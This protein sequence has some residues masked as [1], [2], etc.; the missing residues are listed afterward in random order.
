M[1]KVYQKNVLIL[2]GGGF[3]GVNLV[4]YLLR[5][6]KY[7]ITILDSF[8]PRF[9]SNENNLNDVRDKIELIRG[10]I[11]DDALLK[12]VI[13]GKDII[14]NL[15][16][17]TSHPI[18]IK[19]PIFDIEINCIGALKVLCAVKDFNK[20]AVLVYASS[21]TMVGKSKKNFIDEEH[22]ENPLDIY[23]ANKGVAEKYHK[24]F[25]NVYGVKTISLRF[26][27]LYGPFGKNDPSSGFLN[28]FLNLALN[29]RPITVFG[30]GNQLRNVMFV[31]DACDILLI[32]SKHK[33]LFGGAY[34]AVHNE[35]KSVKE[36]AETVAKVF[37]SKVEFVPY[38]EIRKKMEV[39]HQKISG[40]LLHDLTGWKP[41]Y[42]FLEGLKEIRNHYH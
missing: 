1:K 14:F 19:N 21:S 23:S 32:A 3:L 34:F 8:D 41:N 4:K 9:K 27:N 20:N 5:N 39:D 18:S 25:A 2:G 31:E 6:Q 10:D 26:A 15:A 38:P 35:H 30:D 36:I 42:S 22:S 11:L 17:Q 7:N 13:I 12:K 28:Y 24:I 40:K 33:N 16:A 37:K 29:G